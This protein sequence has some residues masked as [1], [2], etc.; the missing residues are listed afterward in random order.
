M[1]VATHA[2]IRR[3]LLDL[4]NYLL[5]PLYDAT[6]SLRSR[7]LVL[8]NN[9]VE[10]KSTDGTSSSKTITSSQGANDSAMGDSSDLALTEGSSSG[11][12]SVA[13]EDKLA[14]I[15][16]FADL[17]TMLEPLRLI[18]SGL[19]EDPKLF[20]VLCRLL[21]GLLKAD[22]ATA[23]ATATTLDGS[24]ALTASSASGGSGS[25]WEVPA[26]RDA[27]LEILETCLL[28]A[29]AR[30]GAGMDLENFNA[31]PCNPGIYN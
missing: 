26:L 13:K 30:L 17:P 6:V 4:I 29:C 1:H 23:S 24:R 22:N 21:Q 20:A 28:P 2:P 18:G 10:N 9:A 5:Q 16:S 27:V 7:G 14:P 19:S 3:A 11:S 31:A 12:E 8:T 25:L 15:A